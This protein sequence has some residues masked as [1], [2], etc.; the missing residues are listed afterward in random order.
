MSI[1]VKVVAKKC[2]KKTIYPYLAKHSTGCIVYFTKKKTGVC[3]VPGKCLETPG[4][5]SAEWNE[6]D[7]RPFDG[8]VTLSNQ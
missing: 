5:Y 8:E 1:K 4:S 2:E 7:F 3:L 6:P